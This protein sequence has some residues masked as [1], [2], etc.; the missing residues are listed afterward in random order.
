MVT[1]GQVGLG[2]WG[3]NLLRNFNGLAQA[4]VKVCCDLDEAA[5]R[6]VAGQYPGMAITTDYGAL[7]ADPEIE[8]VIVTAPTPAHYELAK[9]A[10]LTGRH[11]FVEKP[12]ALAVAEAEDLVTLAEER[13]RVL[14]VGHLLMYH[15]AVTRLK[16]M[17][18]A[19]ELG[20]VYYLTTSRLNLGQVRRSENAMWSLAPHDISVALHLLGEEP[21]AVA[22]QGLTYLQPG[23]PDTVFLT[24]RFSSG[25]AA[26]IHVS[27]LDPHKVRRITVVGSQKMA[28]FDDVDSTEKLRIYDKG[29]QRPAYDSYGDSLSLRFGDISIPRIDMREPLRLECQHFVDC[30]LSGQAPLSDGRNGVQVLRVLEAGQQSLERGG[31]PVALS[32]GRVS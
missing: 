20:E 11:V 14:M 8:A 25:R 13:Q 19:G 24:L 9:A 27:W 31:E 15:P 5:L 29:V 32:L 10:L 28:V 3:P 7:L 4:R 6:K 26:H 22:A 12:I 21:E 17:V 23:I 16:Q 1:L 30:I 2:Y 18:D